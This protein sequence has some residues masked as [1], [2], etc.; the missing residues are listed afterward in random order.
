MQHLYD[1][2]DK[3][4]D[5]VLYLP[6]LLIQQLVAYLPTCKHMEM[7]EPIHAVYLRRLIWI[8]LTD[9]DP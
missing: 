5:G 4:Q 9:F 3:Y 6:I 8:F 2:I 1:T 7:L